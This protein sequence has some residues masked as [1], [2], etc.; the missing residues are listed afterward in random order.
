MT[1]RIGLLREKERMF[2]S[3]LSD[4]EQDLIYFKS[5]QNFILY[6]DQ[7]RN[8]HERREI[9]DLMES[10]FSEIEENRFS[11]SISE[12]REILNRFINPIAFYYIK[13]FHFKF[14]I[15]LKYSIF[16]G[17]N[18]DIALLIFGVSKYIY[19]IPIGTLLFLVYWLF[20]EIFY[21]KKNKVY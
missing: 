2:K 12:K 1:E 3:V 19:Y 16:L 17:L 13:R 14:Y 9:L 7:L 4:K 10:F 20:I 11:Y 21:A 8:E 6:F 15:G 5:I 18:V